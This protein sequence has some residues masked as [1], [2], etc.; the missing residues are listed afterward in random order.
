M[1]LAIDAVK[2]G[3]ADVAV[4][5]GNTGALMAMAKFNLQDAAGHR[6]AGDRG[7]LADAARANRI[8]LDVGASIGADAEQLVDIAVM[9]S[10]M[11]RVAVRPRPAD[12]R[13]A[14]H[15]RR[16][17]QGPRG[18]ARGRPHP[19][20]GDLPPHSTIIGFVEGDD[21]GKGT[22]DVVVTEG[23][24]GN[25]A[26][27]TAEGT[28]RQIADYLRGAMSRT[29]S[30]RRSAICW[31][32]RRFRSAARQDGPA[33][34]RM[35]ACSSASTAS[36]S[37]ATAAPTPRASPPQS[38]SATTWCA[39]N[40]WPRSA[41]PSDRDRARRAPLRARDRRSGL[42][43][44]AAFGRSR[45]R[46]LSAGAR[47]HQRRTRR[48]RSTPPTNGSCSAP[49]SASATSRPTA[50]RPPTSA[51]A[52]GARPRWPMPASMPQTI[53]LIVLATST[54]D[55]TFPATATSV[56][57]A[58]G[59]TRGAAF[60]LQAVCSGFVYA[61]ATADKFLRI[62]H[63]QARAGDRRRDV[64]AHPRLDR[65]HHLRAVRRRRRRRRAG[66]AASRPAARERPRRARP[67]ICAP[68]AGTRPS[69]MSTAA[70]PRPGPSAI[71]A[72]RAA[73]CSARGRHDHRRDRG[74]LRAP[75]ATPPTTSTG[76]CRIRP[77]SA[78]STPPPHKL[79]IAPEKVVITVDRH[80]NT[81]AASIPLALDVAVSRRPHQ[82]A[83]T[84]CCSRRWA[85][86][87]PGA[88][89]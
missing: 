17:G 85:A 45:H 54:P 46:Q 3:E 88:R 49:A 39:T 35:A 78:S 31:R 57:A 74:R 79:G 71:C 34:G 27:K 21:I 63:A 70:R 7:A 76:S 9:G 84:S 38:T 52:R 60:D 50:R 51:I 77:T 66:G 55:N 53:D 73:R 29:R 33:Q 15:R 6:A 72:W 61:L 41:R 26:L 87:S 81:S 16:G 69:S 37:R 11:A 24:A 10:A 8:V 25:I 86:A 67:R 2:K 20:R 40:C 68:T 59:I 43:S 22:V 89:P 13:A 83:A 75:P 82:D 32:G 1:W 47:P 36:S 58:L 12:R 4:S 19:A 30:G 80:G 28:A 62:R 42:V 65:P 48:A 23:F 18:G 44:R 5:A 64:L 14:Q 56:Q